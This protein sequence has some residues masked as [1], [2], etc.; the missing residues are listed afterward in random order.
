MNARCR[1]IL[2]L[3]IICLLFTQGCDNTPEYEKVYKN[4]VDRELSSGVKNDSLFLGYYFGMSRDDFFSHSWDL[5]KQQKVKEGP[6]NATVEYELEDLPQP[7]VMNF[8]PQFHNGKIYRMPVSLTYKAWAPWN[9]ELWADSLQQDVLRM[10][11]EWYGSEFISRETDK[12]EKEYVS[13]DGNR[14]ISVVTDGDQTV[15]VVFTDLSIEEE[16]RTEK[17]SE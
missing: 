13:V 12:G 17:S 7:A 2:A 4:M 1:Y 15:H 11:N 8:Y 3:T 6:N 10:F 9:R 16:I 5:N 14:K